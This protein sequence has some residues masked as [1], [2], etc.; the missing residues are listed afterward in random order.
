MRQ[1]FG[2]SDL[3]VGAAIHNMAGLYLSTTPA[4]YARAEALLRQALEVGALLQLASLHF[5]LQCCVS[6]LVWPGMGWAGLGWNKLSQA[7][8]VVLHCALLH[9]LCRLCH[10]C[11]TGC[12]LCCCTSAMCM[13]SPGNTCC[14][15]FDQYSVWT[16]LGQECP[17][18]VASLLA[19]V[20]VTMALQQ[21][22]CWIASAS[23]PDRNRLSC[24]N[25]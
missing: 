6:T 25:S 7:P 19:L 5:T 8:C 17:H 21:Q 10:Q 3:R 1:C 9:C 18:F 4:D 2:S 14:T 22:S 16:S 15:C 20:D 23:L 24:G 13:F 11:T 12:S